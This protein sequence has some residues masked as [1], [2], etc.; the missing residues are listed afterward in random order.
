[1]RVILCCT[2]LKD[3]SRAVVSNIHKT[4]SGWHIRRLYLGRQGA[5]TQ[6]NFWGISQKGKPWLEWKKP[7][8]FHQLILS[9]MY[10]NKTNLE[11]IWLQLQPSHPFVLYYHYDHQ[12]LL[13]EE[14]L[15]ILIWSWINKT[16]SI[17]VLFRVREVHDLTTYVTYL[18]VLKL[19]C[20][21]T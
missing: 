12:S 13:I 16:H 5:I 1:M 2:W 18:Y 3:R 9:T 10:I 7:K 17:Q 11:E 4:K 6:C 15:G 14:V 20:C 8:M 19:D 21:E